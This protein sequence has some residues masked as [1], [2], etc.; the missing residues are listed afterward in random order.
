[1]SPSSIYFYFFHRLDLVTKNLQKLLQIPDIQSSIKIVTSKLFNNVMIEVCLCACNIERFSFLLNGLNIRWIPTLSQPNR[2]NQMAW[3]VEHNDIGASL[4]QRLWQRIFFIYTKKRNL[5]E[6]DSLK[7][8]TISSFTWNIIL[9]GIPIKSYL[10]LL[11][12]SIK[13]SYLAILFNTWTLYAP[14]KSLKKQ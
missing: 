9:L 6:I 14:C 11:G 12:I 10:L 3:V 2:I 1:M 4:N 7:M 13:Y 8:T 5:I